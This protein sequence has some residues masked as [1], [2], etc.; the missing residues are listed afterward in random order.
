M[1]KLRRMVTVAVA[2][3]FASSA[4]AEWRYDSAA[5]EISDGNWTLGVTASGTDLTLTTYTAGSG[6]LDF[7]SFESDTKG[8]KIVAAGAQTVHK[9]WF[10]GKSLVLGSFTAPD[11]VTVGQAFFEAFPGTTVTLSSELSSLAIH[12]FL[13]AKNITT[14]SPTTIKVTRLP[15]NAFA[16]FGAS[17]AAAT[18]DFV[19]PNLTG[20]D[21][22]GCFQGCGSIRSVSAPVLT[23]LPKRCTFRD[24][25]I[26]WI[27]LPM[28]SK[29][30]NASTSV[31]IF[32]GCTKL[33]NVVFSSAL[34]SFGVYGASYGGGLFEGC[35]ALGEIVLT[36]AMT[37]LSQNAF[38]GCSSLSNVVFGA[39]LA[40]VKTGALA[41][42]AP[43]AK[44]VFTGY[45]PTFEDGAV[46]AAN[47]EADDA[48]ARLYAPAGAS[49]DSTWL[50]LVADNAAVFESYKLKP[51][52]P[53]E[54]AFGLVKSGT[55]Y[56]WVVEN[57]S[58]R[59]IGVWSYDE[60]SFQLS[61]GAWTFGV[62]ASGKELTL[63]SLVEGPGGTLD[64]TAVPTHTDGYRVVAIA[65]WPTRHSCMFKSQDGKTGP[66]VTVL[67]APDMVR[68]G[69]WAFRG[70]GL[71]RVVLSPNVTK[72]DDWCFRENRKLSSFS[73][74]DMVS[75]ATLG[76]SVFERANSEGD[77]SLAADFS[78]PL[79]TTLEAGVFDYAK[80]VR[81]VAAPAATTVK[82]QFCEQC[83]TLKRVTFASAVTSIGANAFS[84][85]SG[86]A[87]IVF[88]SASMPTFDPTSVSS[89]NA[90]NRV[91]IV[92][93]EGL[94]S[95]SP[96][97]AL[98]AP[99]AAQYEAD[100]ATRTDVPKKSGDY[101]PF[102][103]ASF[104]SEYVWLV[105]TGVSP[106]L[107]LILR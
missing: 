9:N 107:M 103:L 17:A 89:A 3:I 10:Y 102:G 68:V 35:T 13:N 94:K 59:P 36:N 6:D 16:S 75:L 49:M 31:G 86:G 11:M 55:E 74:T 98:A 81:S 76:S 62:T 85:I 51:D 96:W 54:K 38:S 64:F 79:L 19:F 42:L 84:G 46:Y 80:L 58:D 65:D 47:G 8:Y 27:N 48:R 100:I 39:K 82:N 23:S 57:A 43:S 66:G 22:D 41:G 99:N 34:D 24:S 101:R 61:N 67:I 20:I 15:G 25:K 91:R 93:F 104:G 56:S 106:G 12:A 37:T 73:P 5:G 90:N 44:V 77:A 33:T 88:Q 4:T 69:K 92:A 63:V 40:Q 28:V 95:S 21:A 30:D 71:E 78:F 32:A 53:G 7:T 60:E 105:S 14:F 2:A 26:E 70:A 83:S 18:L 72:L 45:A 97:Q 87:E 52:Y 50:A 29:I 1:I